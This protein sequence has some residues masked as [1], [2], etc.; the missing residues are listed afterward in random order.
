MKLLNINRKSVHSI[1]SVLSYAI[2]EYSKYIM[3]YI[4]NYYQLNA[5]SFI[6]NSIKD[7]QV[8]FLIFNEIYNG[9]CFLSEKKN[10]SFCFLKCEDFI[11]VVSDFLEN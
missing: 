8:M 2:Y 11:V 4:F 9:F 3:T 1:N 7:E 5:V 10:D 6:R